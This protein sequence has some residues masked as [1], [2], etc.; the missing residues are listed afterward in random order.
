MKDANPRRTAFQILSRIERDKSYADILIDR[1][2]TAGTLQSR[3]RSLLTELVFGVLRR[4]G[5]LDYLIGRCSSRAAAKLERSVLMLLR[6]GIYQMF[7]L[8][9]VP[10]S[11]AVNET[12][13]LAKEFAPRAAGFVNAVLRRFGR[14]REAISWPDREED[15]AGFLSVRH[16]HPRWLI[17]EWIRMLGKEEAEALAEAM[18]LAPPLTV[19]VNTLRT[20]REGLLDLLAAEGV[21]ALPTMWSPA[22]VR[23]LS[24]IRPASLA[25]FREGLLTV[26]DES[27]Q[28][29]SFFLA[30]LPGEDL[31]DL[32]AAPG[33]KATH[34]AQLMGNRGSILA[35][36]RD[37]RKLRRIAESADRLGAEI[38]DV[39]AQDASL[40]L[41]I[42]GGRRFHRILV[43]APCTG[44]GVIR[45]NPE[46]KW[47]LTP[48]DPARLSELQRSILRNGARLLADG[49]VLLYS[50]CSTSRE[51]NEAVIDDFLSEQG[52]F[53]VEDL[54]G[55]FPEYAPLF[56]E[57]GMF[58]SWPHRHG[59]DGFFAA[60]L[61]KRC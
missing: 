12:V 17:E 27:S 28:L 34:L 54:R 14:E 60:R 59:M 42:P 53:V 18:S 22:G 55:L 4:R 49:G 5:T 3:D 7:F 52:D 45:R 31:L 9:R 6:L 11:A 50:T 61:K 25:P 36:D 38:I 43:D 23:I 15:P 1:E 2:L 16:S 47:R 40:P 32:C 33:G 29:A 30:P 13:K 46:A 51:E 21:E 8:E 48:A 41:R 39:M 35:C 19:R 26:Q 24:H 37:E 10:A 56:T 20:T 44:L 58:R 57:R